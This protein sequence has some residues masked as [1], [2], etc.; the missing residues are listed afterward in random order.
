MC[1]DLVSLQLIPSDYLILA[2]QQGHQ[3]LP[4]V[5][6]KDDT[7]HSFSP[8]VPICLDHTFTQYP[9][10]CLHTTLIDSFQAISPSHKH[11]A[12]N[13]GRYHFYNESPNEYSFMNEDLGLPTDESNIV[14]YDLYYNEEELNTPPKIDDDTI[15]NLQSLTL[16]RWDPFL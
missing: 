1:C 5:K 3:A 16:E 14:T 12:I 6:F 7:Y 11:S 8:M 15:P 9:D 4:L 10:L 13:M 2:F